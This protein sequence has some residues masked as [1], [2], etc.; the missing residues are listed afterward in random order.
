MC[1]IQYLCDWVAGLSPG[2]ATI[3]EGLAHL[4]ILKTNEQSLFKDLTNN[5]KPA[6][7]SLDTTNSIMQ[8]PVSNKFY[9]FQFK[10]TSMNLYW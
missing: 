8:Y 10:A 2:T 1:C 9:D 4:C 3:Y 5:C 7:F 6:L